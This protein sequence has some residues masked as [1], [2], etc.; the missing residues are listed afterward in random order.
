MGSISQPI[1]PPPSVTNYTIASIPADGIGPEVISA[2]IKVLNALASTFKTFSFSFTHFDWSSD[3]YLRTGAYIAPDGLEQLKEFHAILFGAV[4]DQRVPDHISLWGLR[5]AICQPL[6]QYANVRPT[7]I[8]KGV[9]SPLASCQGSEESAKKL[10]WVIIRENSEGEYAGQGGRSHVGQAWEVATEVSVFTRHGAERLLRFAYETA[11][12]RTRKK[13]TFVTKSNAQRNGMVL[14]DEVQKIVAKDYP[15][16]ETD[17]MLVDAMTCRM[18]LQP[19]T[20]DTVV[21]TNLH[22]DILSDLAAALAGSI[23]I[24]P[25]SNL[26]PTRQNPSMFEP[27]HGS[28]WDIAGKGIANPVGTFWTCAE[29]VKWLGQDEASEVLME[30]V[31]NVLGQGIKTKDLGGQAGTEEVTDRV[32]EEIESIGKERTL[33]TGTAQ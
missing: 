17:K 1:Q 7:R 13:L 9:T 24:A 22:A 26:D 25:T 19:E 16:V 23:G 5:L 11:R 20:I 30:A 10:D 32:C 3:T 29:M 27:I 18:T 33:G 14:W 4:G 15:D 31:E 28:A 6:Q 21:A 8:L 12:S 2:G